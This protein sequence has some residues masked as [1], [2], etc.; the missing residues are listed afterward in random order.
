M[1]QNFDH[2]VFTRFNLKIPSFNKS[3]NENLVISDEWLT[4]RFE[5]FDKYCFPSFKHQK[6]TNFRWIVFFDI[7]TPAK[8]K[9][10]IQ[11]YQQDL[12]QFEPIFLD[13]NDQKE[14]VTK[15]LLSDSKK[16]YIIT[17][18]VDNDDILGLNYIE[19]IQNQFE[20]QDFLVVD[21]IDGYNLNLYPTVQL[22]KRRKLSNPFISL[23]EINDDPVT[24]MSRGHSEWKNE[25]KSVEISHA[26][27][28]IGVIHGS[29]VTKKF[30]GH[31]PI[32]MQD[33]KDNFVLPENIL[34]QLSCENQNSLKGCMNSTFN[35]IENALTVAIKRFKRSYRSK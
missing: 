14:S 12:P 10:M 28:W 9:K 11:Q 32:N 16:K 23:I 35:K 15:Q 22:G 30:K 29:N 33:L 3:T 7:D 18:R 31:G 13:S 25:K 27:S 24:I 8:F 26:Y 20:C 1:N 34:Q 21:Q 4:P 17:S 5:L 2:F 6:N 19:N